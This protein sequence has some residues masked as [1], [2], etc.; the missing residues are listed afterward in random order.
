ME[1]LN[2]FKEYYNVGDED[3]AFNKDDINEQTQIFVGD[4][5]CKESLVVFYPNLRVIIGN[6][7]FNSLVTA[8]GLDHLSFVLGDAFFHA[9]KNAIG[10]ENLKMI[11]GDAFFDSLIKAKGIKN[12]DTV[13]GLSYFGSL[14][15]DKHIE[16][17]NA[18]G[19]L[20]APKVR[21]R[22]LK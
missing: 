2:F 5:D 17:L 12:L 16:N 11:T 15:N 21:K 8:T 19:P 20:Y 13:A 9:L 1:V 10:L 22:H 7:Y 6:A 3:I 4:L 14:K 18:E